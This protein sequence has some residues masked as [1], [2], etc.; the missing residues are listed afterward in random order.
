MG[1]IGACR[2]SD[3]AHG[4]LLQKPSGVAAREIRRR[5]Q[6]LVG[7]RVKPQ[8]ALGSLISH[9]PGALR[10]PGLPKPARADHGAWT[11]AIDAVRVVHRTLRANRRARTPTKKAGLVAR[12]SS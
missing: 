12:P 3:R 9:P 10:L 6:L 11:C 2:E 4:A 5:V 7:I 1:A 8:A